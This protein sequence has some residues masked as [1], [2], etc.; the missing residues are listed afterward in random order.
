MLFE[1]VQLLV[2]DVAV[3]LRSQVS[4]VLPGIAAVE[5]SM[6]VEAALLVPTAPQLLLAK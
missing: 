2:V 1:V 4:V 6:L 3:L 5:P